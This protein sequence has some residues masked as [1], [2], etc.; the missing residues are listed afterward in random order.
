MS[1]SS[2][3]NSSSSSNKLIIAMPNTPS[4][5]DTFFDSMHN[6]KYSE[7]SKIKNKTKKQNN[8]YLALNCVLSPI[9]ESLLLG[10][11][12]FSEFNPNQTK[13]ENISRYLHHPITKEI[14]KIGNELIRIKSKQNY[15]TIG[16]HPYI[17]KY[18]DMNN[19]FNE[20]I[21]SLKSLNNNEHDVG[22]RTFN[23]NNSNNSNNINKYNT[24]HR[25]NFNKEINYFSNNINN[26]IEI[27]HQ[28]HKS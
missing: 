15:D 4:Q 24:I 23:Y 12:E 5:G 26:D 10:T 13:D 17:S 21:L 19:I 11:S 9:Q 14:N 3:K 8:F 27:E 16:K 22:R 28:K 1:F 2:K 6:S 20:M 25:R 7:E 18:N